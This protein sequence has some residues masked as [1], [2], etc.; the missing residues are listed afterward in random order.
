MLE[1]LQYLNLWQKLSAD[2]EMIF[3]SGPRQSGKTTL[4]KQIQQHYPNHLHVNWDKSG[5]KRKLIR[6]PTF[7]QD[8]NR[9]DASKPL[10]VFDELHKYKDWKNYLKG[11]YDEFAGEYQF[12]VTGSGR[13]DVYRK[14]GDSLAGRYFLFHLFPFTLSELSAQQQGIPQ[15]KKNWLF[16]LDS[17]SSKETKNIWETLFQVGGFPEPFVKARA[18]FYQLWVQ[19]YTQQILQEEI[20]NLAD[21]RAMN[22][23]SLLYS[24]LPVKIGSPLSL[25]SLAGDLQVSFDSV[26][27]WLSLMEATFMIF[28]I[29]PW[30]TRIHRAI[31][32]EKKYY[33]FNYAEIE[34]EGTRFENM[35]ALELW[36]L[37]ACWN[38]A[39]FGRYALHYLRN[40]EKLEVD[41]LI[42]ESNKPILLI[43]TKFSDESPNKN[44]IFFQNQLHVP[45]LQLIQKDNIY[46]KIKNNDDR[47]MIVTAYRWFSR[48]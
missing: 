42:A 11:I 45:A 20:R 13:L 39:G 28:K 43:E 14:G 26:K 37:I 18:D 29:T 48:F 34:D 24:L 17:S 5:D 8:L 40:K 1:R 22:T 19:T 4:S 30:T 44:L 46:K 32:K 27:K 25:N 41:F 16:D 2:K 9:V 7:F 31:E 21:I 36:R 15:P 23:L 12:L 10:V 6:N 38:E 35:V 47:L 3:I 33:L